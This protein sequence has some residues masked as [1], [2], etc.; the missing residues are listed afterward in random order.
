MKAKEARY[1]LPV[2]SRD[3]D[4]RMTYLA[5]TPFSPDFELAQRPTLYPEIVVDKLSTLVMVTHANKV[6]AAMASVETSKRG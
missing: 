2:K 6:H 5:A 4:E 3:V 1:R